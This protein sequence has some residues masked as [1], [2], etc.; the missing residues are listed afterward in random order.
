MSNYANK[1]IEVALA[2]EGYLEKKTN[3]QLDS[4]T[5]N[6]GYGNY[7]KYARDLDNI[8]NFY[9]GKKQGVAWCDQFVDWCF[10]KAFGV[11]KAK[12]LLG[13][14]DKSFGAGCE[15]SANYY[16]KMGRFYTKNPQPGD[17]I[18]FW[19][20]KKT[21][22]GHTGIVVKVDAVKVYTVEGNTSNV[23]G[24]VANGGCVRQKSYF[25]NDSDIY[26]YGRPDY[27]K[28]LGSKPQ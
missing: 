5:A 28:V 16:K 11:E 14:P 23:P 27:D 7:T 10:V 26:G 21:K 4:K 12:E 24:V 3:A 15:Y 8:P 20:D 13:Q 9:N 1:L 6:A 19:N 17:Q 18:F 25:L 2:E 22:A